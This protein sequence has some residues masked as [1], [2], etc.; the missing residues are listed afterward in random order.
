MAGDSASAVGLGRGPDRTAE[1]RD[2]REPA[3]GLRPG[4]PVKCGNLTLHLAPPPPE[5]PR[6]LALLLPGCFS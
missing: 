2:W 1:G 4:G 6:R 5:L 3:A